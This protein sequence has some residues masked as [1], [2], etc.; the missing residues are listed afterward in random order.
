MPLKVVV[1]LQIHAVTCPG[2]FLPEKH[3]IYL[4]V[5]IM[6]Q[7][8]ET[9][10][11]PPIFPLLFH[12]KMWFEKVFESAVDPAAVTEML[13]SNVTTFG[14][15][16]LISSEPKL[17]PVYPGVERELLMKTS[18]S[19]PGIAPKIEFSTRTTIT[20]L[21]LQYR[22][23]FYQGRNTMRI[24]RSASVSPRRRSISPARCKTTKKKDKIC[25]S[26]TRLLRSRSPSPNA[27]KHLC[28]FCKE[29]QQQQSRLSL[30]S[31]RYKLD[32]ET[33]PPFVVR[34]V[35]SSNPFGEKTSSQLPYRN[36]KQNVSSA[37][38]S[39]EFQ[40]KRVLS[41]DSCDA[42]NSS[43]KVIR[44]LDEQA[45]SE[46]DSSSLETDKLVNYPGSSPTQGDLT[47]HRTASFATSPHYRSPSPVRSHSPL[48]HRLYSNPH[49]SW[50]KIHKRVQNLL[51]SNQA[52]QRLSFGATDSEID[53]VLER[54]SISLRSSPQDD[55]LEQRYY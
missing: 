1:E 23:Q 4:S 54:R 33:R 41:F 20:E 53:D 46:H 45:T 30:G 29:N 51:T 27:T 7:Y 25:K 32:A 9:E 36:P 44:E 2:V 42:S 11:L 12:E 3:D 28:Q 38:N 21:P 18:P 43:V 10:C 49:F 5:C 40:L 16:Q 48:Q 8:K 26:L 13:E 34:H 47:F 50:E 19:F 52:K 39:L 35:D 14:L 31:L 15:I 22:K 37:K 6:G 17:T 55:S 24:Q